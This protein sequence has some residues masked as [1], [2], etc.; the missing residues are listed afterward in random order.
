MLHRIPFRFDESRGLFADNV[1]HNSYSEHAQCLANGK[2]YDLH[3]ATRLRIRQ[4]KIV[5]WRVY[6]DPTPLVAAYKG[7]AGAEDPK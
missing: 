7:M 1:E 4:G 3:V 5:S 2:E 6:W